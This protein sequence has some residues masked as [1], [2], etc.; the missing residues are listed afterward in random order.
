MKKADR[1]AFQK[2]SDSIRYAPNTMF[3]FGTP[4]TTTTTEPSSWDES[5]SADPLNSPTIGHLRK[6]VKGY[7]AEKPKTVADGMIKGLLSIGTGVVSGITGV[8]VEPVREVQKKGAI[9]VVTGVGKGLAGLVTKPLAGMVDMGVKTTQGML[10]TPATLSRQFSKNI[11]IAEQDVPSAPEHPV[12]GVKHEDSMKNAELM[13]VVHPTI[14]TIAHI[15]KFGMET[16][17]IFRESGNIVTIKQICDD[18]D[19][20]KETNLAT[21]DC[22]E[23]SGVLKYYLRTLPEPLLT[24]D[25]YTP[26]LDAARNSSANDKERDVRLYRALIK[27]LPM[28]DKLFLQTLLKLLSDIAALSEINKM[29]VSNLAIVFGPSILRGRGDN[30]TAELFDMPD[31]SKVTSFLILNHEELF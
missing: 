22:K 28:T 12:F 19:I 24:F 13:K 29:S 10:N 31:V 9:G 27:T 5:H 26:F 6:S 23:V 8:V 14:S 16:Q 1:D 4:T 15:R 20:G 18:Y 11:S 2:F 7:I 25:L 17:G 3:D 30:V 21:Y